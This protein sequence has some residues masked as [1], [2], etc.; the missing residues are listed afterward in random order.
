M[1]LGVANFARCARIYSSAE[2]GGVRGRECGV[3]GSALVPE[4]GVFVIMT[5]GS[6]DSL[7]VFVAARWARASPLGVCRS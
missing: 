6:R 7:T 3:A 2:S 5:R 1:A 4:Q